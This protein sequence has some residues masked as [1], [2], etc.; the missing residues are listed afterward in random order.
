MKAILEAVSNAPSTERNS[1]GYCITGDGLDKIWSALFIL[2]RSPLIVLLLWLKIYQPIER[3]LSSL[4]YALISGIE[5]FFT[6]SLS[7]IAPFRDIR[8]REAEEGKTGGSSKNLNCIIEIQ[9]KPA[10][11]PSLLGLSS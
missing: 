6:I 10:I 1:N 2:A 8:A 7:R 5:N 9:Y 3:E 11:V 4:I